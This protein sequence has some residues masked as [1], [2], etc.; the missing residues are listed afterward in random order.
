MPKRF[1]DNNPL[2]SYEI[3]KLVKCK[4]VAREFGIT[5]ISPEGIKKNTKVMCDEMID[6]IK[7][8]SSLNDLD[9]K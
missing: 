5:D 7:N 8:N 9:I 6:K 4:Q 2:P 1:R 3:Y